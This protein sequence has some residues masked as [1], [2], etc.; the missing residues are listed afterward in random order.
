MEQ[1]RRNI[2]SHREEWC[3]GQIDLDPLDRVPDERGHDV[4]GS[5]PRTS[6]D[7]ERLRMG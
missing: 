7:G 6:F 2:P 5:F 1:D 4:Q 3:D